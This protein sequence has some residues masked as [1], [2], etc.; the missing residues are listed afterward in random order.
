[1]FQIIGPISSLCFQFSHIW[2]YF[3]S[4]SELEQDCAEVGP[5]WTRGIWPESFGLISKS[6]FWFSSEQ[7]E[8]D[9]KRDSKF[10]VTG[11]INCSKF[12][13]WFPFVRTESKDRFWNQ[14]EWF[15]PNPS[16]PSRTNFRTIFVQF[17][18]FKIFP[19]ISELDQ[20]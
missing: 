14:S 3:E 6:G 12:C 13:F 5:Y 8:V 2:A 10:L 17:G 11:L 4:K 1:M 9:Q 16:G 7:I 19:M 20:K 18:L 15:G